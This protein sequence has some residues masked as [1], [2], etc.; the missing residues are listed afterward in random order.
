MYLNISFTLQLAI[1]KHF[2][3]TESLGQGMIEQGIEP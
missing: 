1:F 3:T 2:F